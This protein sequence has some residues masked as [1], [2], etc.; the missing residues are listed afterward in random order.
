MADAMLL[1]RS[2]TLA[3][4]INLLENPEET[5]SSIPFRPKGGSLYTFKPENPAKKND[6]KAD[7]H[8]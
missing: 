6:W 5:V 1:R 2:L 3:E 7:G 4:I 8:S